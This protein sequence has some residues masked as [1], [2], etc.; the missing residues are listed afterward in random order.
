MIDQA[1][2][3]IRKSSYAIAL[4]GAGISTPSGIPDFRS[5][6]SGLWN[7]IEAMKVAS[8]TGFRYDP[9]GFYTWIRPFADLIKNAVPNPAHDALAS[10][11]SLGILQA[12]ITQ[13]I[14]MLHGDA[15]SQN[16]YEVHGHLRQMTCINCF[17]E[18]DSE[19]I[20]KTFFE[21]EEIEVPRCP[22][23]GGALKPN[24][25]LFGEQLPMQV[26]IKAQQAVRRA[27]L[28]LVAGSSLEVHPVADFPGQVRRHGGQVIIVNN[29]P[30]VQDDIA[31]IVIR[32][33][34]AE[35]LPA[36]VEKIASE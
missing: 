21:N 14:D 19:P 26:F 7:H 31:S 10:L 22:I 29:Q 33:D 6:E 3:L 23:C 13:N 34:V 15:G 24:V 1:V 17:K 16:V 9:L 5:P 28:V 32:G 2:E 18:Y 27:D 12:V 4:T 36:I 25:I 30:T 35:I 8:L 11:E 20:L